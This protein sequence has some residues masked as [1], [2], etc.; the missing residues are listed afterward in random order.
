MQPNYDF[1]RAGTIL[2]FCA[3]NVGF[4]LCAAQPFLTAG[5]I[6]GACY[7]ALMMMGA[8]A[9]GRKPAGARR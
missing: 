1:L 6:I 4:G 9:S 2:L 7:A 8:T 5:G 3:V